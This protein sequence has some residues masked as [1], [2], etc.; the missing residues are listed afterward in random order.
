MNTIWCA[1]EQLSK[2]IHHY[3]KTILLLVGC[4]FLG[5]HYYVTPIDQNSN[6]Y[7]Y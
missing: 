1:V 7:L 2:F 5:I 4:L 6:D 3:I